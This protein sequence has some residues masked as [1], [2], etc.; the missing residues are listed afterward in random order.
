MD[1][2]L[3]GLYKGLMQR[4]PW[5]ASAVAGISATVMKCRSGMG[6]FRGATAKT[7]T[8]LLLLGPDP[9]AKKVIA[10]V[11][12]ELVFGSE[13]SLLHLGF[14]DGSPA[15][16]E[17]AE[18]GMRYRGKTPIDRLVEAVRIEKSAVIL[19]EDVDKANSIIRTSLVRAMEIGKLADS[20][21]REVS[22]GNTIVVMTTSI[23]S[24]L[25][26]EPKARAGSLSLSEGK[27]A[28]L[29]GRAKIC[30]R[31]KDCMAGSEKVIFQSAVYQNVKV[32]DNGA[33]DHATFHQS[34]HG[35][36][37]LQSL[38]SQVPSWVPKRKFENGEL[39]PKLGAKRAKP[40]GETGSRRGFLNL[41]LN[42]NLATTGDG[43]EEDDDEDLDLEAAKLQSVLA[44]ARSTLSD[45]FCALPDYAVG[46]NAFDFNGLAV[47][48]VNQLGKSFAA[49]AASQD[50]ALEIELGLLERIVACVW[51]TPGG[52][53]AFH[54]WL[55]DVFAASVANA[56]RGYGHCVVEFTA[57][58]EREH[59]DID[60]F[61]ST[62][63]LLLP[64]Q[65]VFHR[66]SVAAAV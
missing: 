12:A 51:K 4:V 8:W 21:G 50:A 9:V 58:H 60:G 55:E 20:N 39:R 46:F 15:R 38:S 65:I 1:A 36:S 26:G 42:L 45:R 25:C 41:D 33:S 17:V 24:D 14:G 56:T 13:M 31:V 6:S 19:L 28:A 44:E 23:G 5:Q 57:E 37:S 32:V 64:H 22:F 47:E 10:K 40:F 18:N 61:A 66:S 49:H 2:T 48:V 63:S 7:D 3:K 53:V 29:G 59:E 11:L 43:D 54:C 35:R 52:K 34:S 30:G 27:L 62:V 16:L